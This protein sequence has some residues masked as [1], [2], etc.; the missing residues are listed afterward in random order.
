MSENPNRWAYSRL[1]YSSIKDISEVDFDE[2]FGFFDKVNDVNELSRISARMGLFEAVLCLLRVNNDKNIVPE[3]SIDEL[4]RSCTSNIEWEF[5][6]EMLTTVHTFVEQCKLQKGDELPQLYALKGDVAN[7]VGQVVSRS[8]GVR[9]DVEAVE[10]WDPGSVDGLPSDFDTVLDDI[11]KC[12]NPN[13][14]A[15]YQQVFKKVYSLLKGR[16]VKAKCMKYFAS[17]DSGDLPENFLNEKFNTALV[18]AQVQKN[19]YLNQVASTKDYLSDQALALVDFIVKYLEGEQDIAILAF[20][21]HFCSQQK[22]ALFGYIDIYNEFVDLEYFIEVFGQVIANCDF[23]SETHEFKG[24]RNVDIPMRVPDKYVLDQDD[25]AN[26]VEKRLSCVFR[27]KMGD[28]IRYHLSPAL[29]KKAEKV[30]DSSKK[31]SA[32]EFWEYVND[33]NV[34]NR[35]LIGALKSLFSQGVG[36]VNLEEVVKDFEVALCNLCSVNY[37]KQL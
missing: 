35:K 2:I 27:I 16:G 13:L 7:S 25:L 33:A 21:A 10:Y 30:R 24:I 6:S 11:I 34:F 15:V 31:S 37:L 14:R 26:E 8:E 23:D 9:R 18:L 22:D 17:A 5:P 19:I 4:N 36:T 12:L 32:V 1:D 28:L 20:L 3:F 29:I